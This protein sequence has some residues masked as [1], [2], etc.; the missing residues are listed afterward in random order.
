[1]KMNADEQQETGLSVSGL[2]HSF[3]SKRVVHDVGLEIEPGEIHC[4][5]GP[6]GCGK[7]TT[8]RLIAGLEDL[9]A[10]CIRWNGAVLADENT[11]V[12]P[13]QRGVSLLFQDFALF[14]HLTVE[15]NV[16]FGLADQ[17]RREREERVREGLRQVRMLEYRNRYP[18]ML[19]GGEQQRVALARARV[20]NPKIILLDE[21]FSSLDTQLRNEVRDLCLHVLKEMRSASLI[22]THDAEEA[23]FMADRISVMREGAIIQTGAPEELYFHPRSK[24]VA[25]LFGD[26]NQISGRVEEGHVET[27]VGRLCVHEVGD[28]H[29]VT[30]LIRP[31]AIRIVGDSEALVKGEV[32]AARLL[33]RTSLL[34]LAV[35]C[36]ESE[37]LHFHSRVP[38]RM[39]LPEGTV[40]GIRLDDENVFVFPAREEPDRS[41]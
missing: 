23:M 12:P 32:V 30:I 18:H 41:G 27:P 13:E 8:L 25:G 39:L 20:P 3:G 24:F 21:P 6:S 4:L 34:H 11:M 35:R 37:P 15:E 38:G 22:V 29:N 33:G 10:G 5:L 19:S 16:G 1:M 17:P 28:G 36:G 40:V 9:Q 14:P 7:T 2:S 26:L 31:E